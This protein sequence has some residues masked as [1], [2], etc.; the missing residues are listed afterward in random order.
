MTEKWMPGTLTMNTESAEKKAFGFIASYIVS[1]LKYNKT[2]YIF[3]KCMKK[4]FFFTYQ[5]SVNTGHKTRL[6]LKVN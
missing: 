3:I 4:R 5:N 2:F 1:F 6:G